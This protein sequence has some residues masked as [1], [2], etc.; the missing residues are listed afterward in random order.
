MAQ[1]EKKKTALALARAVKRVQDGDLEA[2]DEVYRIC[3]RPLHSIL[4]SRYGRR[5]DDF[6][7]EVVIQTLEYGF[8]HRDEYKPVKRAS[9][10]TWLVWVSFN[11]AKK[12]RAERDD[13]NTVSLNEELDVQYVLTTS[14]PAEELERQR[15]NQVLRQELRALAEQDRLSI[16]GHGSGH[17]TFSTTAQRLGLTVPKARYRY[18]RARREM[19]ERLERRGV[20][21]TEVVPCYGRVGSLPDDSGD[22]GYRGAM[23]MANLPHGPDSLEGAAAADVEKEVPSD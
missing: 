8:E 11:V 16:A 9:F 17:W 20:R 18:E 3:D 1:E 5:G 2:Y 15:R 19:K 7:D 10:L 12:V 14:D 6:L 13:H 23:P 22:N 21:P 4:G